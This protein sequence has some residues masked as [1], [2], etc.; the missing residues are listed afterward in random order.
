MESGNRQQ[1]DPH[2]VLGVSRDATQYAIHSA[3][4]QAARRY[5]PDPQ[6]GTG[7]PA[8][9]EAFKEATAA[10][11]A[12]YAPEG[13]AHPHPASSYDKLFPASG[14]KNAPGGHAEY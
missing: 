4:R 5:H 3:Y 12:L 11:D 8:S 13:D 6:G 10:Y 2:D 7:D 14:A 9:V 1:R